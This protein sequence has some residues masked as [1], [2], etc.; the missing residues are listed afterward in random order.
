MHIS[1]LILSNLNVN[2]K[3]NYA[4]IFIDQSRARKIESKW[5]KVMARGLV[6]SLETPLANCCVII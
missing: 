3:A 1:K 6:L 2:E 5:Q 4:N